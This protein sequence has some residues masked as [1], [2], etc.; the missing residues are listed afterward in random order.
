MSS[1]SCYNCGGSGT[2]YIEQTGGGA[3]QIACPLC[4]G[5]GQISTPA[6]PSTGGRGG[7]GGSGGRP[8]RP[9]KP[10]QPL[11]IIKMLQTMIPLWLERL[12]GAICA[13]VLAVLML[14]DPSFSAPTSISG[15]AAITAAIVGGFGYF[16]GSHALRIIL[17]L[18]DVGLKFL[19][20]VLGIGLVLGGVLVL[21]WLLGA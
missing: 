12:L 13:I 20:L 1:S 3:T 21:G 7:R 4:G 5:A 18:V 14:R 11:L 15:E 19:A 10:Y 2:V 17:L 9:P 8:R 6:P 16:L